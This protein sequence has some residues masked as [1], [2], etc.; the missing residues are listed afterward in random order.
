M[1]GVIL[2]G[3]ESTNPNP[4]SIAYPTA[5]LPLLNKPLIEHTIDFYKRNGIRDIAI[6]SAKTASPYIECIGKGKRFRSEERRVGKE[7]RSR[8]S[9]YH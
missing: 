6:L 3:G 5:L 7:C 9:P 2:T 4:L 1:K 8:W